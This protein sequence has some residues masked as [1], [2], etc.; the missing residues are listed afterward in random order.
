MR[1]SRLLPLIVVGLAA[2]GCG[3]DTGLFEQK[4]IDTFS[5]APNNQVDILWVVDDSYS[6]A[7]EQAILGEGFASFA[8]ELDESGTDFQIGVITTSFEYTNPERARL[9]G[10]PPF[11]TQNDDYERLFQERA[12]VGV[13]GS[14]K[15]KGLEAAAWALSPQ[16]TAPGGL[17]EG[18]VRD[19]AQLLVV[20]VSDEEDCSDNGA[21]EGQAPEACYTEA[22]ELTPVSQLV[23]ELRELKVDQERVTLS[24]IVGQTDSECPDVWTGSRYI[25]AAS[26]TGG[27]AGDICESD[28][29]SMLEVMGLTATGI[30][31][32]FQLSEGAVPITIVV[33][34]D[35][36]EVGEDAVNGWT[37]DR[38]TRY[39]EFH[40]DAIP[41]RDSLIT[42]AYT[43]D[44]GYVPPTE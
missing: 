17:N 8:G 43:I 36:D 38:P 18:F 3:S 33:E 44:P 30:R 7:E 9:I 39:V 20:T 25:T 23:Q 42:V 29:H 11:L 13:E 4:T 6:M 2:A 5:Q 1:S 10:D 21:L 22:N 24:A 34:V 28:W 37:Y 15:E 41:P 12:T 16:M 32:T 14:D 31:S 26:Q 19:A 27:L 40:G 35:E